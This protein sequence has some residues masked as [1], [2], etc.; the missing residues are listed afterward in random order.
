ML[1]W[2]ATSIIR[3]SRG[4]V[5]PMVAVMSF[6]LI[7]VAGVA[8][9][10]AVYY[11]GNRDLRSATEAAALSAALFPNEARA[12]AENI[13]S[14]NGFDRSV[15]KS[16]EI[17]RYCPD[18]R[19]PS[20]QRFDPTFGICPGNGRAN[21]V[22]LQ[23]E[24]PSRKYL[25]AILGPINPIPSQS[26][27]ATAARIDEAGISATS[28]ILTVT[29]NLVTSVNDLLG[30]I[31]GVKLRLNANDVEALMSSTVDAGLFFDD[32]A[33]RVGET[34]TYSEL[35]S[36]SVPLRDL[37]LAAAKASDSRNAAVLNNI[38]AQVGSSYQ[39]PLSKLFGLGVWKNMPVGE[40]NEKPALRAGLNAYQLLTFSIQAGNGA[41]DLSD[42]VS[43]A[44]P[45][46]TVRLATVA[47]GPADRPRFSFGPAGETSVSTSAIRLQ[48][49]IGIP[50][51]LNVPLLIDVGAAQAEIKD[52]SCNE[53]ANQSADTRVTVRAT[54]GLASAYIGNAPPDA[55][56]SPLRPLAPSDIERAELLNLL[57]KVD[58]RAVAGP[59]FGKSG[60]LV[61]GPGGQGTIGVPPMAG[62]PASLGNGSQIGPLLTTLTQSLAGPDGLRVE[63]PLLGLCLIGVCSDSSSG[64]QLDI[65]S[66]LITPISGLVGTTVDPLLDTVLAAL[67]IQVGNATVWVTGVRCGVPVLI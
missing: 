26:A 8:L 39:V 29:N 25:T 17:G 67:G 22:R 33:K 41:I 13:L 63:L 2:I 30:A 16:V 7:A 35:T 21:A 62:T 36:R 46:S 44:V 48:L 4:V 53:T 55:M 37:L 51:L 66:A 1:Y 15:L 40:A 18:I 49:L 43:L 23:T 65:L 45:G 54:T 9:D 14:R 38:A 20:K 42:A 47:T 19:L 56:Q 12:R 32:L 34:G 11:V 3:D 27:T 61:F 57:I 24:R 64:I 6:M 50:G 59:I 5:A 31:L 52:I 60:D 58:V 28:N 10:T